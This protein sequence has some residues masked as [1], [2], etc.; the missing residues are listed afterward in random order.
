M[1]E[2]FSEWLSS[3]PV[4][5]FLADTTKLSTWLI[6]PM[7]QTIHIVGVA[8]VMIAVGMLNLRLLGVAGRRQSFGQMTTQYMPWLWGALIVLFITGVIQTVAEPG[9]EILNVGFRIKVVLL[10]V[11]IA[12]TAIY[13]K[14]V[15]TDPNY[16]EAT[17]ERK[18]TAAKLAIFS[19]VLWVGIA[20]AG[21]MIAYLDMRLE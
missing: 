2:G 20:V 9:R 8:V 5:A 11:V 15:K 1:L 13:E 16:W 21:R 17:E 18:Q 12:I 14:R 4:N 7:S 6:V 19:L 3:T 10:A